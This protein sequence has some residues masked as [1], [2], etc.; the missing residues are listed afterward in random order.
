MNRPLAEAPTRECRQCGA[1]LSSWLC[2]SC[3]GDSFETV[4]RLYVVELASPWHARASSR[5]RRAHATD[6]RELP[7]AA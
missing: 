5:R 6:A 7:L 3:G 4:A 2:E 1:S